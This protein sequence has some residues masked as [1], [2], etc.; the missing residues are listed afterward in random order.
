MDILQTLEWR[1]ATKK[2]NGRSVP[3]EKIERILEAIR[4]APSSMGLQPYT[5]LLIEDQELKKQIQPIAFNQSQIVDS[6]HLLVFAAWDNVKPEQIEEYINHTASVR[7]VGVE[8]LNDFKASLLNMAKNR[9]QEQ[10]F[11]W[12]AR[13]AYI[14]F[15]TGLMAAAA[16]KVD[17][18]PM[19][20]FNNAALDE[21]L[22]LKEKGLKSVTLMPLGYRDAENDWLAKLPKV[23]REKEK[24]IISE[25]LV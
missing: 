21:L 15:G 16:E 9:T 4:L 1:Y 20:G 6:S 13:Q 2:M 8:S 17:A 14:A 24:F 18:T 7:N 25:E 3:E 19:E 23:R 5:V 10:N 22:K 11:E 12:A